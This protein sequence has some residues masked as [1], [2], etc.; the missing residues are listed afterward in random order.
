MVCQDAGGKICSFNLSAPLLY[1]VKDGS[2]LLVVDRVALLDGG[3]LPGLVGYWEEDFSAS[4]N[5]QLAPIV[6]SE[7]SVYSSTGTRCLGNIRMRPS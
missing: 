3:E 4:F 2:H 7:A 1:A 5:S 6:Q